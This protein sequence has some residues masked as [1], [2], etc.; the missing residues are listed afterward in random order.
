VAAFDRLSGRICGI[1]LASLV[2]PDCGH[3][4]QICV[5]PAVRGTGVGYELLRHSLAALRAAGCRHTSLTVTASN[6]EA[7]K[8]YEDLGFT[9][10]R[11]FFAYVWAGF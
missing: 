2:L 8:L 10:V 7:V 9:T 11:K 1:C 3:I 4:T 5:A 6:S